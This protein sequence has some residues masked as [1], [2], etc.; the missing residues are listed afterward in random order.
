MRS[1]IEIYTSLC[2]YTTCMYPQYYTVYIV[3]DVIHIEITSVYYTYAQEDLLLSA[4]INSL[5]VRAV[6]TAF[7]WN[8]EGNTAPPSCMFRTLVQDPK[9][10]LSFGWRNSAM[11]SAIENFDFGLG[12][13]F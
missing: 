8:S 3:V 11:K 1:K 4:D 13:D 12:S 2:V 7:L 6:V 10:I 5:Q 9:K